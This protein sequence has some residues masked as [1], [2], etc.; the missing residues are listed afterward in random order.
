M[1]S[2][3]IFRAEFHQPKGALN[4][5]GAKMPGNIAIELYQA[6][7]GT[8]AEWRARRPNTRS[9]FA[10]TP[11]S[12]VITL[13]NQ[14]VPMFFK[15][16]VSEWTAFDSR[17][18]P[19]RALVKGEDYRIDSEGRPVFTREYEEKKRDELNALTGGKK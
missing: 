14:M 13:Q 11:Q 15:E 16:Q 8:P 18:S 2:P 19:P 4:P 5:L 12:Q 1:K 9:E 7:A 10:I 3:I 17:W 6:K